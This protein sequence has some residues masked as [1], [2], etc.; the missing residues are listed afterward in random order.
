MGEQDTPGLDAHGEAPDRVFS[1]LVA[2][3]SARSVPPN[4]FPVDGTDAASVLAEAAQLVE[5]LV[6]R[7]GGRLPA[8]AI[9]ELIGNVAHAGLEDAVISLLDGGDT[10]RVSDRGPGILDKER[11]LLPG[12]TTATP[13]LRGTIRGVGSGLGLARESL[14]ALDGTLEIDDNLGGGTVVTARVPGPID[15]EG[16]SAA[17]DD[18]PG[19]SERQLR[20]L[21]LI[22][23]LGPVGPTPL[24][25]ELGVSASTAYRD[26]V[27]LERGGLVRA[28]EAGLRMVTEE[29]LTYIQTVL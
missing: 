11:A 5:D 15:A 19:L 25:R 7:D 17:G 29:G 18:G 13:T 28:E 16:E 14:A 3:Y 21:L 8:L 1:L 2:H 6:A 26:L 23:E 22:V 4:V 10:L 9:R 12:F 24:A 20:A 27:A